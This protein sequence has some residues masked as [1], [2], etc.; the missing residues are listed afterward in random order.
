M[1][2]YNEYYDIKRRKEIHDGAIKLRR[3][4]LTYKQAEVIYSMSHK[5]IMELA[6]RAEAIYRD[7]NTVLI[8]KEVFD[9]FLEQ[10]H[11]KSGDK[12]NASRPRNRY[13]K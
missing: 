13:E 7:A 9:E 11:E 4:F 6:D 8:N 2:D 5:K 10:F 12:N 1:T 3:Q